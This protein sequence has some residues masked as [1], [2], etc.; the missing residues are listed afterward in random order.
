MLLRSNLGIPSVVLSLTLPCPHAPIR[1][2]FAPS[3]TSSHVHGNVMQS[4]VMHPIYYF[5]T[6]PPLAISIS[7]PPVRIYQVYEVVSG[8]IVVDI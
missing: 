8:I 6:L 5:L 7:F 4:P 2:I 3:G 1:I